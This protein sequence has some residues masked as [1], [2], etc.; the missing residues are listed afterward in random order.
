MLY[1]LISFLILLA[2]YKAFGLAALLSV[3]CLALMGWVM[4]RVRTGRWP[5]ID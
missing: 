2:I 1:R 4:Y 3:I 5:E